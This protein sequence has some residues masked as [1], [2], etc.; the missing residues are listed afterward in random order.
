MRTFFSSFMPTKGWSEEIN[1]NIGFKEGCPIS[2]TLFDI[3]INKLE[4]CLEE[5]GCVSPTLVGIVIILLFFLM[6]LFLWK[7]SL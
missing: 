1:S 4:D 2:P 3:C 6:I 5:V 7:E